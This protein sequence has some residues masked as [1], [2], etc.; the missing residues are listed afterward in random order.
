VVS[1]VE[2]PATPE[3]EAAEAQVD[4]RSREAYR[5]GAQSYRRHALPRS[6]VSICLRAAK[7]CR[8]VLSG[9]DLKR[10]PSGEY[11]LLEANSAPVYLDIEQKTGDPITEAV[12]EHLRSPRRTTVSPRRG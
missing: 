7:L 5:Q 4:Y 11:V 12:L 9:I 3:A 2:I 1:A 6:A 8:H 10:R